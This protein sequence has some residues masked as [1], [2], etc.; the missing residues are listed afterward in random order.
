MLK[1]SN[2]ENE[3]NM[4]KNYQYNDHQQNKNENQLSDGNCFNGSFEFQTPL[5]V[6]P[7]IHKPELPSKLTTTCKTENNIK[8]MKQREIS[9]NNSPKNF[10]YFLN[11]ASFKKIHSRLDC[12][13]NQLSVIVPSFNLKDLQT[14]PKSQELLEQIQQSIS[15]LSALQSLFQKVENS[16]F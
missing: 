13:I 5:K 15:E 10:D 14:L 3:I 9:P 1:K 4:L 12:E 7:F 16:N 6:K 11:S 8:Y 2:E